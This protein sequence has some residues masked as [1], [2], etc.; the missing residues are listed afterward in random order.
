MHNAF[1]DFCQIFFN[2]LRV[3]DS[4][5]RRKDPVRHLLLEI[6]KLMCVELHLKRL[7]SEVVVLIDHEIFKHRVLVL[8]LAIDLLIQDTHCYVGI[9]VENINLG[10][11]WFL[12]QEDAREA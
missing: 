5:Y 3:V 9:L 7:L 2:C 6:E 1:T 8:N 12:L 10:G 11:N 4:F